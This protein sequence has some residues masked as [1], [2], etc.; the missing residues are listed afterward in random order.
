MKVLDYTYKDLYQIQVQTQDISK[1]WEKFKVRATCPERYCKYSANTKGTLSVYNCNDKVLQEIP[2]D[3][4]SNS[5]PVFYETCEYSF[6]IS[7]TDILPGTVPAIIH[8][9]STIESLFNVIQTKDEYILT[10]NINF[11]NQPGRFSLRFGFTS[12]DGIRHDESL[13][14]DVVSPKLNTKEDLNIIIKELKSEY[15]DLVFRYLTLTYQ[16]FSIGKEANNDLIWLSIFK[17]VIDGY[18]VSIRH[19]LNS[20][21]NKH[22]NKIEHL[23]AD[24]IKHW[25]NRLAEKFAEDRKRDEDLA[26]RKYYRNES[27]DTTVNTLEN[28]FIKFTLERMSERLS[29]VFKQVKYREDIS[30]NEITHLA[31]LMKNLD[32]LRHNSFFRAIGRFEGFKQESMVLQ[33]RSGYS[34]VYRYW[35]LLQRGID[36]IDG[37]TSIGVQPIWKLYEIWCF[38]KVKRMVA[39]A[40]GLDLRNPNDLKYVDERKSNNTDPF[41]GGDLAG[42]VKYENPNNGDIIEL[43]YQYSFNYKGNNDG[44]R[45]MT[46]EQK[47]DIVM[48]IHKKDSITLTYLFDAKYRVHGDDDPNKGEVKD[49]PLEDT[50]NQMHRYR[51]AIYYGTADNGDIRKEV[52]GGYILFPGR[53]EEKKWLS[54]MK[55]PGE[56]IA[57]LP[58]YLRSIES[59]NIGAFP[60]LPSEDSGIILKD[61]LDRVINQDSVS[62]QIEGSIPQRGLYYVN[63]DEG[64]SVILGC[65]KNKEH[66]DW[67]ISQQKYNLRLDKGRRGSVSLSNDYTHAQYLVLYALGDKKSTEIYSLTGEHEV[68]TKGMLEELNY[69][70]AQGEVYLVL[71]ISNEVDE[72]LR[73]REWDLNSEFFGTNEGQPTL[74]KYVNIFPPEVEEIDIQGIS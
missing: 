46:V 42:T 7:F 20:P 56:H 32:S 11:L 9:N 35:F 53:L 23:K 26:F 65:Y 10:G 71:S 66:H 21:H 67:I 6:A 1:S 54:E 37:D 69:P 2:V 49:Y 5:I 60:L 48:H 44:F 16:Q 50:I 13:S 52:V 47:P 64:I 58:Y 61:F 73:E 36:L 14:F 18:L 29:K 24:R 27:I 51:D 34:Q 68:M 57:E 19:I 43:G 4:W 8:E 3:D 62:E 31:E 22:I 17:K 63:E 41:A 38:L 25:P 33:Q 28:R 40:L 12:N 70:D 45:S 55:E 15:D 30:E 74:V 39:D 59:I 72:R